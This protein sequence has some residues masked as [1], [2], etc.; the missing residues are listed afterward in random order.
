M[1]A[2]AQEAAPVLSGL[3]LK[4]V[5]IAL[6]LAPLVQVFDT[7]TV[8]ISL[9]HMQGE[10]SATQDQVAW[11]LTSYLITLTVM[12]PLW[13]ALGGIFGRKPLLLIAIVAFTT[14]AMLSG[15]STSLTE[16]LI[17]RACQGMFGAALLPL[18]MS[19]LLSIYPREDLGVAMAW[20]GVGMMF[21]PV[22]G[23]TIGGYV[24]EYLN[25]RWA[26]YLNLPIGLL[27][28]VMVA[29]LV[30]RAG[31]RPRR[32]FNYFGFVTLGIGI[33][34]LQFILDR[35]ERLDWLNSPL[36]ITL[37][38]VGA[39]SLWLF[40]VNSMTSQTPF[41][42]PAIFKDRNYLGGTVLRTLFG[43]LIFGSLVLLPPFVQDIGGYPPLLSGY[44][45]A[46][47]GAGTMLA[48]FLVGYMLKYVDPRKV[49]AA[50]MVTIAFTMWE[51]SQFTEDIDTTWLVVIN[52]VQGLGFGAFMVPLN[53]VA[54]TTLPPEQRDAGTAFYSLLNNIGRSVGVAL[55]SS[56]LARA[57]QGFQ[58][59][60]SE[61]IR[62]GSEVLR[63]VILPAPWSLTDVAGIAALDRLVMRQSKLLA[64]IAD[65]QLLA[66][67]IAAC[68]PILLF[69]ND[70]RKRP[71]GL[72]KVSAMG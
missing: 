65:F 69:M 11:V 23:P 60:L 68:M 49:I 14:F 2:A 7:T 27:A 58:S 33:A 52:F 50:A 44:V 15:Q 35:G 45:L 13:G 67:V 37:A 64:Y 72:G 66:I 21:G 46:P 57:S 62:P 29:L 28:F 42:D 43:V 8:A 40:V 12:T 16:V 9:R 6:I 26:F 47:R 4:L 34:A 59:T 3:R 25:W 70:P 51:F 54:F 41:I 30:P 19:S 18:A 1:S 63:H 5:T 39:G 24:T 55:F 56:Y 10:L 20:W 38:L 53:S 17:W 61:A 22:F 31:Q 71:G 32:K 48:S 36:I